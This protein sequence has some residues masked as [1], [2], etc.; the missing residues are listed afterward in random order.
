MA[1]VKDA[2]T[3]VAA[4]NATER[5]VWDIFWKSLDGGEHDLDAL[6]E[7]MKAED[8]FDD[9]GLDSLDVTDFFLR[10]QDHFKI[11]IPSDDYAGLGSIDNVRQYVER[12][13][14]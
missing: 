11:T 14:S 6:K 8:A 1:T 13:S 5:T 12:R 4:E 2:E 9:V 10:L 7:R 3:S